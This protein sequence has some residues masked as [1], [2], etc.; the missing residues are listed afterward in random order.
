[1]ERVEARQAI[2]DQLQAQRAQ[3]E[4]LTRQAQLAQRAVARQAAAGAEKAATPQEEKVRL[5]E[6]DALARQQKAIFEQRQA[7]EQKLA[8]LQ[9]N[10]AGM[11]PQPVQQ[12]G[13]L[14]RFGGFVAGG[15]APENVA[16][17]RSL[18]AAN[19]PAAVAE[20]ERTW[21]AALEYTLT[22]EQ[23][24]RMAAAVSERTSF[25]PKTAVERVMNEIDQQLLL[26]SA[27]REKLA[28]LVE[29]TIKQQSVEVT[30]NRNP[31]LAPGV[32]NNVLRALTENQLRSILSERQW[33]QR[34]RPVA[35]P[36]V[37][38]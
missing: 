4:A 2:Q 37:R 6:R 9:L 22:D 16:A 35:T 19:D 29:Q 8:Q 27:Q 5:A 28:P 33:A 18:S 3:V 24:S 20:K 10:A 25:Q 11:Q 38:Y 15:Q 23:K 30:L 14:V 31:N 17:V 26:D 36:A 13:M 1:M 21:S 34:L 12:E 32:A 7:L